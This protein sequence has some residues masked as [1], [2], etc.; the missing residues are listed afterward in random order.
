VLVIDG[1]GRVVF[2]DI[3]TDYTSRTEVSLVLETLD[4]LELGVL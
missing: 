4:L 2:V 3:H 1:D